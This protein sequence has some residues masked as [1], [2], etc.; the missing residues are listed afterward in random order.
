MEDNR[1]RVAIVDDVRAECERLRDRLSAYAG[2]RGLAWE[3]RCFSGG[4]EFLAAAEREQFSLVF[5]DIV[6]EDMDGLETARRLRLADGDVP[7]VFVTSEAGY[8]VEGYE[9]E[10]AGFLVKG[11]D[12]AQERFE[13][14]MRRLEARL[15]EEPALDLAARGK[16]VHVP[17]GEIVCAEILDH[18]MRIVTRR[19]AFQLRMAMGEL[20]PLLDG[21]FFECHRGVAV[22]LD[23]VR[24]LGGAVVTMDNGAVLP[25]SRRRR[26]ALE[27]AWAARRFDRLRG[28]A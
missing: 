4:R 24:S 23:H 16:A 19:G 1:L 12:A 11:D 3:L 8:A 17:V 6:M 13:R 27:A 20:R 28:R 25:V 22:N 18:Q 15:R 7:V 10:A 21:R 5:L 9:V 14:L 26:S 2:A